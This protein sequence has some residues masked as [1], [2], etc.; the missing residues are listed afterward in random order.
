MTSPPPK[1]PVRP[2]PPPRP[3]PRTPPPAPASPPPGTTLPVVYYP[4]SNGFS[5]SAT[6]IALPPGT[7]LWRYGGPGGRFVT[8]PNTA[9]WQLSLPPG[10]V[11]IPTAYITTDTIPFVLAGPAG[12]WFGQPGGGMQYQLPFPIEYYLQGNRMSGY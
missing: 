8:D 11:T 12:P 9:P 2:P 4:P 1:P 5:G 6:T 7:V 10:Q 3:E